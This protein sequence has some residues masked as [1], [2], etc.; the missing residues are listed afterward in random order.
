[1]TAFNNGYSLG[2][3]VD[4]QGFSRGF[5]E[6][7]PITLTESVVIDV[8]T[9]T[10]ILSNGTVA[11]YKLTLIPWAGSDAPDSHLEDSNKLDA[12]AY[13]ELFKIILSDNSSIVYLKD[14]NDASWQGNTYEGTGIKLTGVG[15]YSDDETAR[16]QL[17]LF[18]P[19]GVYSSLVDEGLL[20]NATVI[21]TRILKKHLEE[22]ENI[23]R[24][25]QWRVNRVATL[26]KHSMSLEL[27]DML[28]G[29]YFL[30]PGR[31]YIPPEFPQVNLT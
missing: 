16:P 9:S 28:D 21:R 24:S 31:M 7:F 10:Y 5:S 26:T 20:D 3:S 8:P 19:K 18:N 29:Q 11:V 17:T 30:T 4:T 6:G 25:Q 13:I 15:T 14:S 23:S 12:D 22:D 1:M 2:F 27:R